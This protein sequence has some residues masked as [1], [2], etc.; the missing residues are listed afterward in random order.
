M[1]SSARNIGFIAAPL[2][3][4]LAFAAPRPEGNIARGKVVFENNCEECHEAYSRE[5]KAGP[6]L[7][8]LKTGKLPDGRKATH[9][10]LLDIINTG[11]A[12]MT[13]FKDLL[14]EQEKEDVVAFVMTL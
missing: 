13:S 10:Q 2:F 14:S 11:P 8:G 1:A 5:E 9:D 12:E 7:K 3:V 4:V 6:G